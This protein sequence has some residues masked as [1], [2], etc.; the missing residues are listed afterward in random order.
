MIKHVTE[1]PSLLHARRIKR[2]AM[3]N[4]R[5]RRSVDTQL[6]HAHEGPSAAELAARS[7]G[8]SAAMES[9]V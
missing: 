7:C 5:R 9:V 8:P 4:C 3:I 6:P 2:S 1:F